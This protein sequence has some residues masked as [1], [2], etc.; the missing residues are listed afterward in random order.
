[1]A[2]S[3]VWEPASV[4][5]VILPSLSGNYRVT[6]HPDNEQPPEIWVSEKTARN[7]ELFTKACGEAQ[8]FLVERGLVRNA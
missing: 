8:D 5:V 7:P 1:M 2:K 4:R 3:K 6:W